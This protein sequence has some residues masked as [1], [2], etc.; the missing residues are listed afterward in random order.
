MNCLVV[1][2]IRK[3]TVAERRSAP[4]TDCISILCTTPE[5]GHSIAPGKASIRSWSV[6]RQ[7]RVSLPFFL[8]FLTLRL[9]S[10]YISSFSNF[11]RR[12]PMRFSSRVNRCGTNKYQRLPEM[13]R[14]PIDLQQNVC[15]DKWK[16]QLVGADDDICIR[17]DWMTLTQF[18][19]YSS[20]TRIYRSNTRLKSISATKI[21]FRRDIS[22]YTSMYAVHISVSRE[23]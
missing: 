11:L 14:R 19:E 16:P 5:W 9:A 2:S 13:E 4:W 1:C 22:V 23:P 8:Y 10:L 18:R 15:R 21:R 3:Y 6:F 12:V 7:P 17:R 20:S